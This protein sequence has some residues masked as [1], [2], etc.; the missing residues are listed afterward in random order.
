MQNCT[1]IGS[2]SGTR[3]Y[4]IFGSLKAIQENYN[5]NNYILTS[6]SGLIGTIHA[7]FKKQY[8]INKIERILKSF[9][10]EQ[11]QDRNILFP[12]VGTGLL[13]G[14]LIKQ[15][16]YKIFKDLVDF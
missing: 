10:L 1:F 5:I 6:G 14:D 11:L 3:F 4:Y 7:V 2:G 9:D 15:T 16:L 8:S 13:D 12:F